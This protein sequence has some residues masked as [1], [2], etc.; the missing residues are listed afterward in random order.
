MRLSLLIPLAV[1]LQMVCI[2]RQQ[3]V[4]CFCQVRALCRSNGNYMKQFAKPDY[5]Y[6]SRELLKLSPTFMRLPKFQMIN[7][8]EL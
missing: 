3:F 5:K 7:Y 4:F 2:W 8:D 1:E 6:S